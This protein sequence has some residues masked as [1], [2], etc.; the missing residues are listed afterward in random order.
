[1]IINVLGTKYKIKYQNDLENSK[2]SDCNGLCE[3]YSKEII[4]DKEN[5]IVNTR[6]HANLGEFNKKVIRHEI[7]H[8]FLY[9]SGLS[10]YYKDETLTDGLAVLLPKMFKVMSTLK[11]LE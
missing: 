6:K 10:S 3:V 9:E 8:A 7:I 5:L 2:L 1:M 11:V 4:I